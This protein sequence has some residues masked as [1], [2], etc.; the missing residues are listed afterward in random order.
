MMQSTIYTFSEALEYLYSFINWEVERHVR[1]SPEVMTLDRPRRVMEAFGN[2]HER[3]PILHITGTKGKGSVGAMVASALQASGL[4]VGLYSSPHLQDFRERFRINNRLI[5]EDEFTLLVNDMRPVLNSIPDITWFEVT[6]ALAFLYFAREQVDAAVIEV[7][8]GGR[9]DATNIVM[10]VAAAIT[11]ISY[12]HMHLLG[13]SLASIAREKGGIIKPGVPIIS[14]PQPQ[15]ALDVL[16]EIAGQR[17]APLIL[18]GRDWLY[19]AGDLSPYCQPFRAGRAGEPLR[20]YATALP[21][22]HQALNATVALAALD[23]LRQA[24]VGVTDAGLQAG[25]AEVDWPGRLEVVEREPLLV[26]DA[27]HNGESAC[28]LAVALTGAFAQRPIAFVF[29]ASADKDVSG[30]FDHLLPIA[31]FL[32]ISQAVHPRA[33]DP[34]EIKNIALAHGYARPIEIIPDTRVALE[35]AAALVGPDGLICTT[36][37]LFIIGEVRSVYGLPAG[38]VPRANRVPCAPFSPDF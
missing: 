33:L 8:L 14:A 26:L 36:G 5:P 30:M 27:A 22:E 18:V 16:A 12:D 37:S 9:L 29:G 17:H 15:E 28:R 35:R 1:Y 25:L 11:S 19:E 3:Y 32:I 20:E 4:K 34:N 10:P 7:G 6:T 31:D 2:P 21:G 38:H 24:G 23:I 13:N